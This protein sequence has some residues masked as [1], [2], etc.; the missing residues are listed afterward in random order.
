VNMQIDRASFE[1]NG[2]I[3]LFRALERASIRGL[4]RRIKSQPAP[5][6]WSKGRAITS[7][8]LS[9]IGADERILGPVRTLFGDDIVLWGASM[10]HRAPGQVHP[11]HTDIET[12]DPD[13]RFL[14]AWIGLRNTNARSALQV[15]SRSHRFRRTIQEVAQSAGVGRDQ[16]TEAYLMD[17]A[18]ELDPDSEL[19]RP[20]ISDGDVILFDGH[21]WHGS[22]NANRRGI[23]TALLL[24]YSSPDTPIRIPDPTVL[25]WP[26]KFHDAPRPA[27]IVVSGTNGSLT[28]RTVLPPTRTL[29]GRAT[30]VQWIS[31][32]NL[33]LEVE[34]DLKW[35]PF[36]IFHSPTPTVTDLSCHVS[37]LKPGH[38]PHPPHRHKHEEIL[39]VLS[40]TPTLVLQDPATGRQVTEI[41]RRG[42]LIYYPENFGHTIRNDGAEP[43]TYLMFKWW[44]P[45]TVRKEILG[46]EL[47][48]SETASAAIPKGPNGEI[49]AFAAE[50]ILHASTRYLST[51]HCHRSTV[52]PGGGYAPHADAYDVAIVVL[53]G[54]IETLGERLVANSVIFYGAGLEHGMKNVGND[55]AEYL[56]FEFHGKRNMN[57]VGQFARRAIRA[58]AR[59]TPGLRS[60][61]RILRG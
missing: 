45:S 5:A 28:N 21:L 14:S 60:A 40:G 3:V 8:L 23:R 6:D 13:G 12:S 19:I 50:R 34:P 22:Q 52:Q 57:P 49:Q 31:Q 43:A 18:R 58:A 7:P 32:L 9:A 47:H 36:S 24:Q 25:E 55:P 53:T 11:W 61:R 4:M 29:G 15:V 41:V 39:V 27:C 30:T 54:T 26:F 59:R 38:S 35:K 2:F 37:V 44:E 56:V 20:D 10:V 48:R 33:P 46:I 17:W 42:D 16:V 1:E 51:L